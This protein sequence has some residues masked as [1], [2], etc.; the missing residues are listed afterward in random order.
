M[1]YKRL[2]LFFLISWNLAFSQT[3]GSI[4]LMHSRYD[5]GAMR[6]EYILACHILNDDI[7]FMDTIVKKISQDD[8]TDSRLSIGLSDHLIS[9]RYLYTSM[10]MLVDIKEK[11][12]LLEDGG[13]FVNEKNGILFFTPSGSWNN[14]VLNGL[15]VATGKFK[16]ILQRPFENDIRLL[17]PRYNH[18]L[19]IDYSDGNNRRLYLIDGKKKKRFISNLG[20]GPLLYGGTHAFGRIPVKWISDTEFLYLKYIVKNQQGSVWEKKEVNDDSSEIVYSRIVADTIPCCSGEFHSYN[21]LKNED[22]LLAVTDSLYAPAFED[23]FLDIDSV[24]VFRNFGFSYHNYWYLSPGDS[25]LRRYILHRYFE[26]D[27]DTSYHPHGF[28]H[29]KNIVLYAGNTIGSFYGQDY[30]ELGNVFV[31]YGKLEPQ[32]ESYLLVWNTA[33]KK[34]IRRSVPGF[35][36]FL[37]FFN[38]SW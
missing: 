1:K 10:E 34:W 7:V 5:T 33:G 23:N 24:S 38:K 22:K 36:G 31:A 29:R 21:I 11:K 8:K 20:K 16:R 3:G 27:V 25:L 28:E 35:L 12:I 13:N 14:F 9:D 2:I 6:S 37:G 30:E 18:L 15:D 32:G 19:N 26:I 17:S 4:L